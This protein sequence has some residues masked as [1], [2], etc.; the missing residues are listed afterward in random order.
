MEQ[1]PWFFGGHLEGRRRGLSLSVDILCSNWVRRHSDLRTWWLVG[2]TRDPSLVAAA[3]RGDFS[4]RTTT[5][6]FVQD[7]NRARLRVVGQLD[8][9]PLSA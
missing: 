5:L 6:N 2:K 3:T 9:I 7:V 4:L 1:K 8:P